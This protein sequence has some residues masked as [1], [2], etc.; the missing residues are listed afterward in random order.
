MAE[1]TQEYGCLYHAREPYEVLSTRWLSYDGIL[2]L[3]KVESAVEVYYNSGQFRNTMA[4]LEPFFP[5]AFSMYEAIGRYYQEQE[6]DKIS[7]SRAAPL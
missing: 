5:D 4:Y 1:H 3:K 6:L 2:K 7:H